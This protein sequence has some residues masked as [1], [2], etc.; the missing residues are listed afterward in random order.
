MKQTIITFFLALITLIS[1]AQTKSEENPAWL[2]E[3]SGNG[4]TQ[5]SYLFGTCHGD[6]HIFTKEEMFSI[7][8]LET[9]LGKVEK[10]LFEGGMDSTANTEVDKEA[11]EKFIKW[12]KNPGQEWMMP[13]GTYYKPLYDTV[14]HFNEVNKFLYYKMKDP[15]YW[16]KNPG[17][18]F[19]KLT[20]Y[21]MLRQ[22][23]DEVSIDRLLKEEVE[24]R[25]IGVGFVE[26]NTEV[27]GT[28]FSMLTDMTGIDT[29][30][31]KRQA[32]MLYHYIHD[33]L[34]NDSLF[35][36]RGGISKAYLEN[37]TCKFWEYIRSMDAVPGAESADDNNHEILHDR[38]L[39]WIP[40]IK[41]NIAARPCMIAVGCRHLMGSESLIALL[42][43]DGYTVTPIRKN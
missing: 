24:K 11:I 20:I 18:W 23:K 3:I 42:R 40:V 21:E 33:V 34:N 30:P 43:R 25:S 41:E 13:Q 2:W 39:L 22:K 16:K 19:S 12:L 26:K 17:Y 31:M 15:E 5:K 14:A 8:G 36:M 1:T 37:D 9:A 35:N 6:G 38:N 29:I 7:N 10:V 32:N 28:L 27:S 4:I